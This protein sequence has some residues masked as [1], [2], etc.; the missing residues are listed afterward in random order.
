MAPYFD[1]TMQKSPLDVTEGL[2]NLGDA[3]T[4]VLNRR[5]KAQQASAELAF[6]QA[7]E[8]RKNRQTDASIAYNQRIAARGET[9]DKVLFNQQQQ[10]MK[11]KASIDATKALADNNPQLA[12]EIMHNATVYDP[13]TGQSTSGEAVPGPMRDVGP[14]PTAPVAPVSPEPVPPE[15]LARRRGMTNTSEGPYKG[16]M[17]SAVGVD[18][19][20]S[21]GRPKNFIP[22]GVELTSD[23]RPAPRFSPEGQA[24]RLQDTKDMVAEEQARAD[25]GKYSLSK[26]AFD[27]S[28][29]EFPGKQAEYAAAQRQAEGE[30][31]YTLR[32]GANDPGVQ[33]TPEVQREQHRQGAAQDFANHVANMPLTPEGQQAAK[34]AHE[35]ILSG[36]DPGVVFK[37]FNT[38]LAT[39]NMNAFKHGENQFHEGEADRRSAMAANGNS[40]KDQFYRERTLEGFADANRKDRGELR[41]ELDDWEKN[42]ADIR[43]DAGVWKRLRMSLANIKADNPITQQDALLGLASV[44]R[45]G[46]AATKDVTT[47]IRGHLGGTEANAE[48]WLEN[49]VSGKLGEEQQRTALGAVQAAGHEHDQ[50]V[51]GHY[52]SFGKRF[53]PGHG[54][55]AQATTINGFMD[56]I[57]E[58]HGLA[59]PPIYDS[60]DPTS[61]AMGSTSRPYKRKVA[62]TRAP[63]APPEVL[64]KDKAKHKSVDDA[65]K[66]L[67]GNG[68]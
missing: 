17:P 8:E 41:Q 43:K 56:G 67:G 60:A 64:A 62:P 48:G 30:R 34:V 66:A 59:A 33:V 31:P 6:K 27:A 16:Q 38:A 2:N 46:N 57:L 47:A 65:L 7:D 45:G 14:A 9:R 51:M 28:S 3:L 5:Q 52:R 68:P 42:T 20:Q 11:S 21:F 50:Q 61:G 24:S 18:P 26:T 37:Q 1:Y 4:D 32:F 23:D 58:E 55:E 15:I 40:P 19:S 35:M 63:G 12:A 25:Q 54:L 39:G 49:A 22:S 44:F 36:Q 13:E 29:A 53:G 10:Q